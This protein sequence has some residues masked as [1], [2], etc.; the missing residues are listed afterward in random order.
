MSLGSITYDLATEGVNSRDTFVIASSGYRF[1][2]EVTPVPPEVPRKGAS[3]SGVPYG[4]EEKDKEIK[5]KI[6]VTAIIGGKKYTEVAYTS[7]AKVKA[8]DIDIE[9]TGDA[10]KPVIKVE[11]K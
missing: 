5:N 8:S 11:I 10:E 4:E 3:P 9:V 2:V 7:K 6:T 1:F